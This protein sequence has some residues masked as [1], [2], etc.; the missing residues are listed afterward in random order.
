MTSVWT[1]TV[2]HLPILGCSL[3]GSLVVAGGGGMCVEGVGTDEREFCMAL[4]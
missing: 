2:L 4:E 3:L 1:G